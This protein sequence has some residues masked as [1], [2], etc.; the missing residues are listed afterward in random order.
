MNPK[1]LGRAISHSLLRARARSEG[2]S[3]RRLATH[4]A[5]ESLARDVHHGLQEPL[6]MVRS[7]VTLLDARL[8]DD[9]TAEEYMSYALEGSARL[10]TMLHDLLE[11][12]SVGRGACPE[13]MSL[14]ELVQEV[15]NGLA[16][17]I[18]ETGA[19]VKY[20]GLP[21]VTYDRTQLRQVLRHLVSN[22][23]RFHGASPPRIEVGASRAED[24]W[25]VAVTDHGVGVDPRQHDRIFQLFHRLHPPDEVPGTG[26]GLAVCRHIVERNGG[27]IGVE[28][29]GAGAGSTFWFTVRDASQ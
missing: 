22:A 10:Q 29:E 21:M 14:T 27:S 18:E 9:A 1:Q 23:L 13:T 7:F 26:A 15:V 16:P 5:L 12:G 28:S 25:R 11:L 8:P 19:H 3:G 24:G 17:T 20:G 4:V 6:R 2:L